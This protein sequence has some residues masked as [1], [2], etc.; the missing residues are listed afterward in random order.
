MIAGT[1]YTVTNRFDDN[2]ADLTMLQFDKALPGSFSLYNTVL[3]GQPNIETTIVGYGQS[4]IVRADHAGFDIVGGS[5]G[6]QRSATNT[7]GDV[8]TITATP[9]YNF[10]YE[11][12]FCDLDSPF[13]DTP[14]GFNRDWFGDGSA[15][16]NE[17][18]VW[19]GDSGGAWLV[20]TPGGFQLAGITTVNL[21]DDTATFYTGDP[22][23]EG[24]FF[25][26]SGAGAVNLTNPGVHQWIVSTVPE[27]ATFAPLALG[28]LLLLRRRKR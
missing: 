7:I 5:G 25:G 28:A 10:T 24:L 20:D 23:L 26:V 19:A 16:A 8:E 12:L 22:N 17:G 27:P 14:S 11:G 13:T 6:T 4:G 9:D 1:Q 3:T 2:P 21:S 18:G 15:T